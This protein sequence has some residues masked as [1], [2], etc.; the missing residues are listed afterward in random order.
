MT[1]YALIS[2]VTPG[3][4]IK[5]ASFD[6]K[7]DPNPAKGIAWVVDNPPS[8][9]PETETRTE[10]QAIAVDATEV[11]YT[12]TAKSL[13]TVKA[14]RKAEVASRRYLAEVG[15]VFVSGITVATDRQS[16]AMIT[17]AK[18]SLDDGLIQA[19]IDWKAGGGFV[20]LDAAAL[21]AVAAAVATHV[22]A[23]FT[24]EKVLCAEIDA[25]ETVAAVLEVDIE[26]GW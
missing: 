12:V 25:C 22:Q 17:G 3:P 10:S 24:N 5:R 6:A 13:A 2:T 21:S 4:V 26:A 7:P 9:N 16:Q 15:G 18:K 14:Q 1:T 11:P 8:F 23:C 19:P 20:Q